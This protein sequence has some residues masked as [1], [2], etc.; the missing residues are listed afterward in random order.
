MKVI[1]TLR[2]RERFGDPLHVDEAGDVSLPV[3][4]TACAPT[5]ASQCRHWSAEGTISKVE[6]KT[7]KSE[8]QSMDTLRIWSG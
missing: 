5:S 3:K 1:W 2:K 7:S 6:G 8:H 4:L